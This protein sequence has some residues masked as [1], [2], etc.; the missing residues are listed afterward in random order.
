MRSSVHP[1]F[2][3]NRVFRE[4]SATSGTVIV[5]STYPIAL[6]A[7]LPVALHHSP[8]FWC[9]YNFAFT[10]ALHVVHHDIAFA[11][12][13]AQLATAAPALF[14]CPGLF[15]RLRFACRCPARRSTADF[16]AFCAQV[17]LCGG[18]VYR[19]HKH[20][21]HGGV[22]WRG[23]GR[24]PFRQAATSTDLSSSV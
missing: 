22:S 19:V 6:R 13:G 5:L 1:L 3:L 8:P 7:R 10:T 20:A 4:A 9:I 18:A 16:E 2:P 12:D 15:A 17:G 14:I 23:R 11:L 21:R 24:P